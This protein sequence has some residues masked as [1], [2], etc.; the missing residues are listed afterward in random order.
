MFTQSPC[1]NKGHQTI[2][3]LDVAAGID[4]WLIVIV[5]FVALEMRHQR[6]HSQ[7]NGLR[8]RSAFMGEE[9]GFPWEQP[10]RRFPGLIIL[11]NRGVAADQLI[12]ACNLL[13][14]GCPRYRGAHHQWTSGK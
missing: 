2:G 9:Q 5:H 14:M 13:L 12:S 10:H 11:K 7:E 6:K 4:C 8:P 1:N 3:R